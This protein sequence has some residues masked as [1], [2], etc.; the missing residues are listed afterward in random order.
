MDSE[1]PLHVLIGGP[2]HV[3]LRQSIA[4]GHLTEHIYHVSTLIAL[5]AHRDGSHIGGVGLQHYPRQGY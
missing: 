4:L 3:I 2:G 5:P 1:Y